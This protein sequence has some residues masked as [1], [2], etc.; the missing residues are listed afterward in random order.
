MKVTQKAKRNLVSGGAMV[1]LTATTSFAQF[2]IPS[3]VFDPTSW[4]ELVT[5]A[6]TAYTQLQTIE[7]NLKHFSFKNVWQTT[8]TAMKQ[9][10][11]QN[12]FGETNGMTSALNTNSPTAASAAW[13]SA[14]VPINST[15][16]TYLAGQNPGSAQLSQLAMI[17]ASDSVSPDCLNAVGA[18]RATRINDAAP[19][20]ALQQQQLDGNDATNSE[21]EQLNL[22]NAS[23]A[24]HMV[25]MQSQGV[26]HACL[27]SQM[28]ISNMQQRNA[29]V[30]DLNT[31]AFVK[32]QQ[33]A[34]P[35]FNGNGSNTWTTYL[36]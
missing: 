31:A 3:I 14:G 10:N 21:V 26:L 8:E 22:L 32:Q 16:T 1:V 20:A 7:N 4:G 2:G 34:N 13:T 33:A 9:A 11:V 17:E 36:P 27:A 15:T 25:E 18:Y 24:Q 30:D 6:A 35:V 29:A 5:Q 12:Q 23:Q 19:E 28:A